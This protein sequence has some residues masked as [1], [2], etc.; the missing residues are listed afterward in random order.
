MEKFFDFTKNYFSLLFVFSIFQIITLIWTIFTPIPL[1]NDTETT[2]LLLGT[3]LDCFFYL[4]LIVGCWFKW[5]IALFYSII[6]NFLP[7][8]NFARLGYTPMN[9]FSMGLQPQISMVILIL[10]LLVSVVGIVMVTRDYLR[11]SQ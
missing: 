9:F 11:S 3:L 7:F 10:S 4:I 6:L 2:S 1:I 8:W 5:K